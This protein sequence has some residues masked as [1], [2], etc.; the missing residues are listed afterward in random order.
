VLKP[1]CVRV[2][3]ALLHRVNQPIDADSIVVDT[4]TAANDGAAAIQRFPGKTYTRTK[5][6]QRN[7]ILGRK[8]SVELPDAR[9]KRTMP[10]FGNRPGIIVFRNNVANESIRIGLGWRG[11]RHRH[12]LK[13]APP[14]IREVS[15]LVGKCA[16]T[17]PAHS[18][19]ERQR[20]VHGPVVLNEEAQ[21]SQRI[22]M[23]NSVNAAPH[24]EQAGIEAAR[25]HTG[26]IARIQDVAR[27][28]VRR[29]ARAADQ[30]IRKGVHDQEAAAQPSESKRPSD[31]F[32]LAPRT[33]R[34]R[35]EDA[36][37]R[38]LNPNLRISEIAYDVG[39]QSLTQFNRTFKRV[40]G[41]SPSEFRAQ[42]SSGRRAGKTS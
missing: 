6:T 8:F 7:A 27:W 19:V 37:N 33:Q 29:A 35:L 13:I 34:V 40:F 28:I 26:R 14:E 41:Q 38:L 2:R 3:P 42:V 30:E 39:F 11:R 10:A 32:K 15:V 22:I 4:E 9:R 21:V 20:V 24:A 31:V 16:E 1:G 12:G 17:L 23:N 25:P 18:N 36:R 5:V